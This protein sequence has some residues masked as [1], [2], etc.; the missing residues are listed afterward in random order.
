MKMDATA[1]VTRS[2]LDKL[3]LTC[4][5]KHLGRGHYPPFDGPLHRSQRLRVFPIRT[6]DL[7][8]VGIGGLSLNAPNTQQIPR[9]TP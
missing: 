5:I 6:I 8:R 2:S 7:R 1:F 3:Q 9:R 4:E